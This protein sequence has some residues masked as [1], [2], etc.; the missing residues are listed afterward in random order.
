MAD[1]FISYS[2]IDRALTEALAENL[3]ARGHSVWWDTSLLAGDTFREAI[4]RELDAA[5]AAIVIWSPAS[6][7]SDWV[8]SE[9][10]RARAQGKLI[11][12]RSP[13]L[14]HRDIPPPFDVVHTVLLDERER[15]DA[16]IT[17]LGI[18]AAPA[19]APPK[20][21]AK[22]NRGVTRWV[23]GAIA[24]S[25]VAAG[26]VAGSDVLKQI[27]K[28]RFS[29]ADLRAAITKDKQQIERLERQ[30]LVL[31]NERGD[32]TEKQNRLRA[33]LNEAKE[34]LTRL[35]E[36]QQKVSSRALEDKSSKS[37]KDIFSVVDPL[38]ARIPAPP[39]A[40]DKPP[41]SQ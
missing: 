7:K 38:P 25:A 30:I 37:A 13:D 17:R 40:K 24:L 22:A 33:E 27:G 12:V 18:S 19:A 14:N 36:A 41:K 35:E 29:N 1:I 3:E 23:A 8:V 10:T 9:A 16:A 15:I 34:Q 4:L 39:P 32:E 31:Q 21:G 5:K 26:V 11:T 2:K 20:P 28:F 6:V